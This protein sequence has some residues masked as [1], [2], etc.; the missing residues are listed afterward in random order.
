MNEH[1][2]IDVRKI[3]AELL[4]SVLDRKL[5]PEEARNRWPDPEGDMDLYKGLNIL[6]NF[7]IAYNLRTK[8]LKNYEWQNE[9]LKKVILYFRQ[10]KPNSLENRTFVWFEKLDKPLREVDDVITTSFAAKINGHVVS[11]WRDYCVNRIIYW[12]D[13]RVLKFIKIEA[14]Y[15]EFDNH[16]I[17]YIVDAA[18]TRLLLPSLG[19]GFFSCLPF[20]Y[21]LQDYVKGIGILESPIDR[22]KL[23]EYLNEAYQ[24]L[25]PI[26]RTELKRI[27]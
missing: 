2:L 8:N 24:I 7:E 11:N 10:E 12:R 20:D 22:E 26:T 14:F 4:Q 19:F 9:K 3:V 23:L 15:D 25:K 17:P 21:G 6:T 16:I 18:A 5:S 27:R 1:E 13:R